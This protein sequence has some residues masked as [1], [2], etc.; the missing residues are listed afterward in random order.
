MRS[1]NAPAENHYNRIN[2]YYAILCTE[3]GLFVSNTLF[4]TITITHL[5]FITIFI[6]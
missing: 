2:T 6:D 1:L 3:G 4:V 5:I